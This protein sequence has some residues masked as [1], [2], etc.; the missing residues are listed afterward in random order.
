MLIASL[1]LP[2][3]GAR[4]RRGAARRAASWCRAL[5]RA[6]A[7]AR[8]APAGRATRAALTATIVEVA[9]GAAEIAMAGREHDWIERADR[10]GA[11][12]ARMQRRDAL[13]GGLA[14]GLRPR[15]AA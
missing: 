9:G 4:P 14:G 12:L 13:A 2:A 5:T 6:A 7:R 1:M 3:A 8:G 11:R 15:D 10:E